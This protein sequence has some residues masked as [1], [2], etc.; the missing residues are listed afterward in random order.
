MRKGLG[1]KRASAREKS[2]S[3]ERV[4][5]VRESEKNTFHGYKKMVGHSNDEKR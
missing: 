1:A 5:G 2:C 3:N 4:E